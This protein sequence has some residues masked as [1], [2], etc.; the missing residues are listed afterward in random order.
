MIFIRRMVLD[1]LKP[2]SPSLQELAIRLCAIKGVT[3][4]ECTIMEIDRETESAKVILE[5]TNI[6]FAV[7]ENVIA[8]FGAAVHSVDSVTA[9]KKIEK[10][11]SHGS[12]TVKER[13]T[14][15]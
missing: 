5:G 7:V 15:G 2:I 14:S 10:H 1:V 13:T 4:A 12:H 3:L 8:S 9:D 6:D 11:K